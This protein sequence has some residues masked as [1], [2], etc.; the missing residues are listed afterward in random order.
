MTNL[1]LFLSLAILISFLCSILEAVLLSTNLPYIN[2]IEEQKPHGSKLLNKLKS[3]INRPIAAIL[4]VN[5]IAHTVGAAGVGAESA[6]LFGESYMILVSGI[7]T[8]LILYF[9]EI[10]PKTI[11]AIYWKKLAVPSAYVIKWLIYLTYPLTVIADVTTRFFSGKDQ[12]LITREELLANAQLSQDA[13]VINK[14]ESDIIENILGLSESVIENI[15][16]PRS[17]VFALEKNQSLP[18]ILEY[19]D[20]LK[21]FS[22][23]PVYDHDID[24][25]VGIALSKEILFAGI[26]NKET[27]LMDVV[28]P[29]FE[30]EEEM[31]VSKALSLMISRREQLFIV[32]D[33]YGQT[34]GIVTM[35]DC[36]ET[37]LGK[38][39]VD[40]LDQVEDLQLLAKKLLGKSS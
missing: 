35:E 37:L 15:L 28:K 40:E 17:V 20:S 32:K 38:E 23:I 22:R 8:L 27:K 30:I 13:G 33:N 26:D 1:I 36:L 6:K 9:S 4:T 18:E 10:I 12:E 14:S 2:S 16:T 24:H 39:I 21:T 31:P 7:L 34:A 19:R 5:T 25:I 11:G 29:V 3:E